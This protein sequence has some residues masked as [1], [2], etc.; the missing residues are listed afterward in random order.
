MSSYFNHEKII[1]RS[2]DETEKNY[3]R[4]SI[5]VPHDQVHAFLNQIKQAS[6]MNSHSPD[7]T[8][9]SSALLLMHVSWEEV[10]YREGRV[11]V[12]QPVYDAHSSDHQIQSGKDFNYV[13]SG[14]LYP[15]IDLKSLFHLDVQDDSRNFTDGM[16]DQEID[17]QRLDLGASHIWDDATKRGCS[18]VGNLKFGT[19]ESEI[20]FDSNG[21]IRLPLKGDTCSFGSLL[22]DESVAHL[23]D[24]K[25]GKV[26]WFGPVPSVLR[27]FVN[28]SAGYY[29]FE[30]SE[31]S[32]TE[33]CSI[34]TVVDHYGLADEQALRSLVELNIKSRLASDSAKFREDALFKM[35][36]TFSPE[37]PKPVLGRIAD[38]AK[39][40]LSDFLL[41]K[42]MSR[43]ESKDLMSGPLHAQATE[44]FVNDAK[45]TIV[46]QLVGNQL[47]VLF[48]EEDLMQAIRDQASKDGL[49]PEE[50][51][52]SLVQN[53][54]LE[55]FQS[56]AHIRKLLK[57]LLK[58]IDAA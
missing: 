31:I 36:S 27:P 56:Q 55:T 10:A 57:A 46:L 39:K 35:L 2:L 6:G 44:E 51:R 16:I 17:D 19:S 18:L 45:S 20:L 25:H 29:S 53:G 22:L 38:D 42:G 8:D 3:F 4:A 37:L 49:R 1:I 28:A 58:L 52:K 43:E 9:L 24:I 50:L 11:A 5:S 48:N 41:K 7:T 23:L 40:F 12:G 14:P 47:E 15:S 21:T 30:V 13:L 32:Y 33:A 54:G 26:S 34:K